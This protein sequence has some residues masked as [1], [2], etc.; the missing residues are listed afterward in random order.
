MSS[1]VIRTMSRIGS[2]SVHLALEHRAKHVV[3]AMAVLPSR[4]HKSEQIA[5]LQNQI[6]ESGDSFEVVQ[7]RD[8][9]AEEKA[10]LEHLTWMEE[11]RA[12]DVHEGRDKIL[13]G[14][15]Q[16]MERMAE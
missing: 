11:Q 16:H 2:L 15:A 9:L 7:L 4:Q 14:N 1:C 12:Q 3:L 6:R 13:R 5:E 8:Q 10:K